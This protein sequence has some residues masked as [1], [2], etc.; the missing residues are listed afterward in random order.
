[1]RIGIDIGGTNTRIGFNKDNKIIK[2]KIL[3]TITDN[4]E[5]G[6][7]NIVDTILTESNADDVEFIGIGCPGP[8]KP[9][10]SIIFNTPNMKDWN[11]KDPNKEILS[12]FKNAKSIF[13]NDANLQGL[14]EHQIHQGNP[15]VF[16]TISTGIGGVAIINNKILNGFSN[17]SMEINNA[18]PDYKYF[19]SFE[20]SGIEFFCSGN[21]IPKILKDYGIEVNNA[22][23]AF[24]LYNQNN[25]IVCRYFDEYINKMVQFL[26]TLIY[27][28]NPQKI[29]LNGPIVQNN[30]KLF[31]KIFDLTC[32]VT[33]SIAYK[34]EFV[35]SDNNLES[36]LL[37]ASNLDKIL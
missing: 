4:F 2:V 33:K 7:K 16:L 26:S 29:V 35:Y 37:T 3:K 18:I 5:L 20:K 22:K 15:F 21:N 24:D 23:E 11:N 9:N 31:N 25:L 10:T 30:K 13:I 27:I 28:I 17:S 6:I 32:D 1:M 34:T 19:N 8:F 14:N 12:Y 36:V